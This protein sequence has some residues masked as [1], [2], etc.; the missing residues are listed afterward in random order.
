VISCDHRGHGAGGAPRRTDGY[1]RWRLRSTSWVPV[2]GDPGGRRRRPPTERWIG[3]PRATGQLRIPIVAL[4]DPAPA[5]ELVNW[6]HPDAD[7]VVSSLAL[8]RN[9]D[10]D[11]PLVVSTADRLLK[12]LEGSL[13]NHR[14]T[15]A[16]PELLCHAGRG[17]RWSG[18]PV[19][20]DLPRLERLTE[21]AVLPAGAWPHL[22]RVYELAPA[23]AVVTQ[24]VVQGPA[25][26]NVEPLLPRLARAKLLAVLTQRSSDDTSSIA[27]RLARLREH[28]VARFELRLTAHGATTRITSLPV[29]LVEKPR[30]RGGLPLADLYYTP[31]A[32]AALAELVPLLQ[33]YL[34]IADFEAV[35]FA[36]TARD[37]A[38]AAGGVDRLGV[39]EARERL[40]SR[41]P[42]PAAP[43]EH[44]IDFEPPADD[45][46]PRS[47]SGPHE[48]DRR[49]PAD[50]PL[51]SHEPASLGFG[52]PVPL[53]PAPPRPPRLT[54]NVPSPPPGRPFDFDSPPLPDDAAPI[55]PDD[56]GRLG[57]DTVVEDRAV[58]YVAKYGRRVLDAAVKD[59]QSDKL[60]GTSSSICPTVR[61]SLSRSRA[62][63]APRALPSHATSCTRR[64]RART[65]SSTTPSTWQARGRHWCG[66]RGL[67]SSRR[68]ISRSANTASR[69]GARCWP[70]RRSP[71]WRSVT[72]R[73]GRPP[74]HRSRR[75]RRYDLEPATIAARRRAG[76]A[77]RTRRVG[78][79]GSSCAT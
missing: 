77:H 74:R 19:I 13:A 44:V 55:A 70:A 65:G 40:A 4:P 47:R 6:T 35:W 10:L 48:G 33:S 36:L 32:P 26:R 28:P 67:T 50:V 24:Q 23:S 11:D 62:A 7:A 2:H 29:H 78:N 27:T 9:A 52:A 14:A 18:S 59:V 57:A 76:W 68:R 42:P 69:P 25:L 1:Q 51:A 31:A 73:P 58:A 34:G 60:G 61:A 12:K 22:R 72:R 75:Q 43:P 56:N 20:P 63:V 46:P 16:A 41:R 66:S 79:E 38:L 21:L 8:L 15:A 37:D 3:T 71:S 54:A 17:R 64:A 49:R 30:R 39:R 53:A 45:R 5:L